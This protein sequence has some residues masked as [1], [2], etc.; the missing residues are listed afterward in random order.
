MPKVP[1][2]FIV[3]IEKNGQE[4]SIETP[5][6]LIPTILAMFNKYEREEN[7]KD[8]IT[9]YYQGSKTNILDNFF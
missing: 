3:K 9:I 8:N 7:V 5:L 1:D 6:F 2:T 4:T